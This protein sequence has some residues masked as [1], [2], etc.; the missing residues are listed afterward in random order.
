MPKAIWIELI[1]CY[2]NNLL[3]GHF[4]IKKTCN[5][6]AQKYY[7]PT[8]CHNV[9]AYIKGYNISL[10]SNAVEHK[11]HSDFQFLLVFPQ[12]WKDLLIDFVTGLSISIDWKGDNYNSI[13]VIVDW[14]T[15]MVHYKKVK[16]IINNEA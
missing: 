4:G 9:K 14:L 16:V 12:Q 1:R 8:F 3:V 5:L 11:P 15:K 10:V 7:W 2:H 6:L 13:W